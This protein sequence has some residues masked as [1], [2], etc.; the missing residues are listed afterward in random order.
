[1]NFMSGSSEGALSDVIELDNSYVVAQLSEVTP[2][3]YRAFEDVRTEL[4]PRVRIEKKK[5]IQKARL[6]Q[7]SSGQDDLAAV[8]Q[9]L[10]TAVRTASGVSATPASLTDLG[11]DPSFRGTV[12]GLQE[13]VISNVVTGNTAAYIAKVTGINEPAPITDAERTRNKGSVAAK[14]QGSGNLLMAYFPS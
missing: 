6:V 12:L 4:E 5:E 1:M 9:S 3:G 10:G 2:E 7:A 13:G 8:A 11:N 14:A